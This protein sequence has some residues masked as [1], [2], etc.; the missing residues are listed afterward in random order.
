MI[1]PNTLVYI[2]L[3]RS[4]SGELII[5]FWGKCFAHEMSGISRI[6]MQQER[7]STHLV[8]IQIGSEVFMIRIQFLHGYQKG[9]FSHTPFATIHHLFHW[10]SSPNPPVFPTSQKIILSIYVNSMQVKRDSQKDMVT[11]NIKP[12]ATT[13]FGPGRG[14]IWL[15]SPQFSRRSEWPKI[16]HLMPMSLSICAGVSPEELH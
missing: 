11:S 16:T 1:H 10:V 9:S 12:P 8:R 4:K 3:D 15:V 14:T 6:T 13:S 5:L 2:F 7:D